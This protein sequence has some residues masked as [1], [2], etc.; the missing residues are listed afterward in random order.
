MASLATTPFIIHHFYKITLHAVSSNILIIPLL[1]M[2]IMPL[3][4]AWVALTPWPFLFKALSPL[5]SA[6][7]ACMQYIA[8]YF[9]KLQGAIVY[10]P[11]LGTP[12]FT[13]IVLGGLFLCL[14]KTIL[15]YTGI[16]LIGIGVVWHLLYPA[17]KPCLLVTNHG[18]T[19]GV[20]EKGHLYTNQRRRKTF[21][22]DVWGDYLGVTVENRHRLC[23]PS[24]PL[25]S[26]LIIEGKNIYLSTQ[27]LALWLENDE[28]Q[29]PQETTVW[30]STVRAKRPQAYRGIFIGKEALLAPHFIYSD[31]LATI[32][33]YVEKLNNREPIRVETA[34][35]G[36]VNTYS[37]STDGYQITAVGEVPKTTVQLIANSVKSSP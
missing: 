16:V 28:K 19:I 12:S 7:I 26:E 9:S 15:R 10:M 33:I 1:S 14:F 17:K 6:T 3:L 20:Y 21:L 4:M 22:S 2:I 30:V 18:K 29:A 27:C 11:S 37:T 36:G 31:G 23:D 8:T 32:S 25:K 13:F 5:I 34:N 24:H 35:F